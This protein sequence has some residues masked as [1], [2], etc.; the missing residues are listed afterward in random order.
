MN[1]LYKK[2]KP[3]NP[4]SEIDELVPISAG[5]ELGFVADHEQAE[6]R[7]R[8]A[9][10]HSTDV[11]DEAHAVRAAR[12][13]CRVEDQVHLLALERVHGEHVQTAD[14][15][16]G[17]LRNAR[18]ELRVRG[19]GEEVPGTFAP[20][21][22]SKSRPTS[23]SRKGRDSKRCCRGLERSGLRIRCCRIWKKHP[24]SRIRSNRTDYKTRQA[25]VEKRIK[26]YVKIVRLVELV[27]IPPPRHVL[28][29]H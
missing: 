16:V 8:E 7:P 12:A 3:W 11:R 28:S 29:V 21:R 10:V 22:E 6:A 14:Q 23:R 26:S 17:M 20:C 13:H 4:L 9:H 27:A 24:S 5:A 25:S 19:K 2:G 18:F 1:W 15:L